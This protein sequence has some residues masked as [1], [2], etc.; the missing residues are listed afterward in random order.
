MF[1]STVRVLA[2]AFCFQDL[3]I[4]SKRQGTS[5]MFLEL[6]IKQSYMWRQD[7]KFYAGRKE[8]SLSSLLKTLRRPAYVYLSKNADGEFYVPKISLQEFICL[9]APQPEPCTY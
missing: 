8:F 5:V 7:L 2:C 6:Y 9:K 4:Y 1:Q 3:F